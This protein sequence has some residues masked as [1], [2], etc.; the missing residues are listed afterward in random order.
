MEIAHQVLAPVTTAHNRDAWLLVFHGICPLG[1]SIR[2]SEEARDSSNHCS[3]AFL[4][5]LWIDRQ[6]KY[7][8]TCQLGFDEIAALIAEVR[9]GWLQMQWRRIIDF[10][11]NANA[12]QMIT[13]LIAAMGPNY[14]LIV[15]MLATRRH[16][17]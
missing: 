8:L 3:H 17:R 14:E 5:E 2:C 4:P 13:Q 10:G 11:R 15:H 6:R 12:P 1:S 7:L 9:E 16:R